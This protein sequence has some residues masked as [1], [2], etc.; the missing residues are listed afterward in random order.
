MNIGDKVRFLNDVGGGKIVGFDKGGLV[1]VEDEDGFEMPV[2]QSDVVVVEETN[3][4]NFV[5]KAAPKAVKPDTVVVDKE[6]TEQMVTGKDY[7]RSKTVAKEENDSVDE[8]LEAKV[9]RLE[10]RVGKLEAQIAQMKSS[11][12]AE[13]EKI[14]EEKDAA[15]ARFEAQFNLMKNEMTAKMNEMSKKAK[16]TEEVKV[17]VGD[18]IL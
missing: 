12:E 4:Y 18:I 1:L 5:K 11:M 7:L 9:A 17:T 6:G 14:R 2:R 16:K 8:N 15:I 3:K 10:M 13:V